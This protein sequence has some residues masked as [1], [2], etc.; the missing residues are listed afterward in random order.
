MKRQLHPHDKA[1]EIDLQ[2]HAN[3]WNGKGVALKKL[4]RY[5]CMRITCYDKAI[6]TRLAEDLQAT[7]APEREYNFDYNRLYLCSW[8]KRGIY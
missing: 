7:G 1:I 8:K 4:E 6:E 2:S 3:A 5:R